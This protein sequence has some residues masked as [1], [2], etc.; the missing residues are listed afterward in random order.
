MDHDQAF[1]KK[2][3]MLPDL[4]RLPPK[5]GFHSHRVTIRHL[6][7]VGCVS[8]LWV[9]P[10]CFSCVRASRGVIIAGLLCD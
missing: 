8:C 6:T 1:G 2:A 5:L 3:W 4:M 7:R 10:E 9:Q